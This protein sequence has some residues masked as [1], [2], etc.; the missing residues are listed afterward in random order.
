MPALPFPNMAE[1]L[2]TGFILMATG[3]GTVFALLALLVW[4]VSVVSKVCRSLEPVAALPPGPQPPGAN[5]AADPELSIVIGAAIKAHRD[6][7]RPH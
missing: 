5:S 4:L 2:E 6:R 3:M 1:L 7:R